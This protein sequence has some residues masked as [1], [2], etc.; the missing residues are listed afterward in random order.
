MSI[1]SDIATTVKLTREIKA[2]RRLGCRVHTT[3]TKEAFPDSSNKASSWPWTLE[4]CH[5]AGTELNKPIHEVFQL[6]DEETRHALTFTPDNPED[7]AG[8]IER[9]RLWQQ[10]LKP[11]LPPD[12]Y[13]A[14]MSEIWKDYCRAM[15]T[16]RAERKEVS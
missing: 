12:Q 4:G 13:Y 2:A 15:H 10:A 11:A 6:F 7:P 5:F 3:W 14:A 8:W 16:A 1:F 9:A